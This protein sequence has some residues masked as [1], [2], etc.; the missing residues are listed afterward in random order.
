MDQEDK[1][2]PKP[3]KLKHLLDL[4]QKITQ[5]SLPSATANRI[6]EI[7]SLV[8]PIFD[9]LFKS[10]S[11]V[12]HSQIN[13]KKNKEKKNQPGQHLL[14]DLNIQTSNN[15]Y[16]I[17][18]YLQLPMAFPRGYLT[19]LDQI[20]CYYTV[21]LYQLIFHHAKLLST[22]LNN[23][24]NNNEEDED[25]SKMILERCQQLVITMR[26]VIKSILSDASTNVEI[27]SRSKGVEWLVQSTISYYSLL[28]DSKG[29]E[30][31][32]AEELLKETLSLQELYLR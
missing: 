6:E 15:L 23:T 31:N 16:S 4:C 2:S 26:W 13:T 1:R 28:V 32:M 27:I 5:P 22:A 9:T 30:S 29:D 17:Q 11:S 12:K 14:L 3:I 20:K 7:Q 24:N 8:Q 18:R 19:S 25:D 10:D 21:L